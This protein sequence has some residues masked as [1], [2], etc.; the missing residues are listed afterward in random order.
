[1][2]QRCGQRGK[3]GVAADRFESERSEFFERV[4]QGY[5]QRAAREPGRIRVVDAAPDR[6]SVQRAVVSVLE[7]AWARWTRS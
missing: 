5:L 7:E 4:R 1:M 2:K 3:R 6:A